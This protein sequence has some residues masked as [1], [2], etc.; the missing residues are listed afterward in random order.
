MNVEPL[1]LRD[2]S[3]LEEVHGS[4]RFSALYLL[5][6]FLDTVHPVDG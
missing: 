1:Y 3:T 2:C 4:S 6:P 5:S